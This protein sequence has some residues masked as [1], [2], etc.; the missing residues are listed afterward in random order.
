MS[1]AQLAKI[2]AGEIWWI[3]LSISS[4]DFIGHEQANK[5]PCITIVNNPHIEM[6]TII[7]LTSKLKTNNLPDTYFLKKTFQNGLK[8]DSIALIF[9]I[10]SLSYGRYQNKAGVISIKDLGNLKNL[11]RS[12]FG[13]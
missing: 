5:R 1:Y 8:D 13:L 7:P 9:Q 4:T 6:T 12:Y 11:M 2:K 10:R 3:Q